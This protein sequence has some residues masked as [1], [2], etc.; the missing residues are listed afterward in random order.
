[1]GA[2]P[3]HKVFVLYAHLSEMRVQVNQK[4]EANTLLGK[5]GNTG[6]STAPHLHMEV[7]FGVDWGRAQ[8]VN[9]NILFA[10]P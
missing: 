7:G 10:L 3:Q 1:M 6:N 9:P 5:A 2:N 4:L 8:K